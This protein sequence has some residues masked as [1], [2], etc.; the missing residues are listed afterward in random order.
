M[1]PLQ[2]GLEVVI[3]REQRPGVYRARVEAYDERTIWISFPEHRGR[4]VVPDPGERLRVV[5]YR[6]T[7]PKGKFEAETE[8]LERKDPVAG[9]LALERPASWERHQLREFVRIPLMMR[10]QVERRT[11]DA[12]SKAVPVSA[13]DLSGG[14]L[15]LHVPAYETLR[16]GRGHWLRITLAL[17]QGAIQVQ[18]DVVRVI[19]AEDGSTRY[20]VRFQQIS[21]RDRDRIIGFVLQEEIRQRKLID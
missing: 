7:P 4:V 17:P 2:A 21:E 15:M 13:I 1:D 11:G 14:G 9:R 12:W 18:G 8:V 3:R 5:V 10:V 16:L 6:K 20:A 19:P